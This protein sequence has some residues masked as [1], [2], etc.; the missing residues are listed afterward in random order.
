[1]VAPIKPPPETTD[2]RHID[3]LARTMW[4]EA[5]NQGAVG[6][7]A[8]ACVVL[9][10]LEV[11]KKKPGFWWGGSVAE[12]CLKPKQFSCWNMDDP[13]RERMIKV[14]EA[15]PRFVDCKML[16]RQAVTR[17]V[18][19][20]TMGATHYHT[21]AVKPDWSGPGQTVVIRDH[22]FFRLPEVPAV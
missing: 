12:I 21:K 17:G 13:N 3:I 14:T 22:V 15:D 18:F 5:R 4:G 7:M 2:D 9:N 19:D 10:R 20:F 8:V 6:M 1:M 16:A 11:S